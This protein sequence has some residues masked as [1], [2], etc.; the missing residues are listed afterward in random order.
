MAQPKQAEF[1]I[2]VDG[3]AYVW[4][5]QRKPRWSNK[6]SERSGMAIAV[7]HAEG[8]R[9]AV[10][11]FPPGEQPQFGGGQ[12][13]PEQIDLRLVTNAIASAV[14]AGWDPYSRGRVVN[15]VV[16]AQGN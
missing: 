6:P 3:E 2:S 15:I 14:A 9:E 16:D 10:V 12:L 8:V 5:L 7:R 11:E 4:R 13:R 1:A